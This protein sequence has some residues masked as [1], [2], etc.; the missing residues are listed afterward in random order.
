MDD[1]LKILVP[2]LLTAI[3]ALVIGIMADINRIDNIQISSQEYIYRIE[4]LEIQVN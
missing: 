3:G 2:V 4:Q 1:W